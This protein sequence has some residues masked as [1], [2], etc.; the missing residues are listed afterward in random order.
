MIPALVLTAGLGTRLDPITRLLA[1]AAVPLGGV[2]LIERVLGYLVSQGVTDVVLNLHH[3][4]ETI[5]AVV[6][7]GAHIGPQGLRV[8]YSWEPRL[9]GSAG[10]P[11]HALPLLDALG[12]APGS[13]DG[14]ATFALAIVYA[15]VPCLLKLGALAALFSFSAASRRAA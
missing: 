7:D 15:A 14:D 10:G 13:R 5:A 1:K 6:G 8:R 9:L 3:R 4:P 12:Y 2:T 11:R